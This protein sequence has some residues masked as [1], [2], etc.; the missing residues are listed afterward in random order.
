MD[1]EFTQKLTYSQDLGEGTFVQIGK[2]THSG[3]RCAGLDERMVSVGALEKG[4][5]FSRPT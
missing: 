4:V 3:P 5:P 2:G 1:S